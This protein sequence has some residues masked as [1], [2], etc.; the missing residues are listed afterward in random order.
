MR[1]RIF[2]KG[3]RA[4]DVGCWPKGVMP[5]AEP[6]RRCAER[7]VEGQGVGKSRKEHESD[8]QKFVLRDD[9]IYGIISFT[10][11]SLS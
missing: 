10:Y 2:E 7:R 3:R 11:A 4:Q 9:Q 5:T 8:D 1:A 6:W